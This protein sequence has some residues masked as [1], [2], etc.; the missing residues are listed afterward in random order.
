MHRGF[1]LRGSSYHNLFVKPRPLTA[2]M[3]HLVDREELWI[4][5]DYSCTLACMLNTSNDSLLANSLQIH[6]AYLNTF[7]RLQDLTSYK[8]GTG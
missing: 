6:T 1:Q 3:S 4:R 5:P 2:W 8:D 7:V